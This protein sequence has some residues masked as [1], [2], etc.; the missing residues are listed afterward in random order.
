MTENVWDYP[1]PPRLE[2]VGRRVRIVLGGVTIVDTDDALRVL[3]TSHPPTVYV[4]PGAFADGVLQDADGSSYCEWKG[5]ARYHD[6]AAGG[7]TAAR[8][9]WSYP[10]PTKGFLDLRD[11][12]S[13][14]PSRMEACYLDEERVQAQEGDFYGGWITDDLVGPF[15]GGPGTRGW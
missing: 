10:R 2:P 11:H 14:Y 9:G 7:T 3:E 4:P 8:A 1:R 5:V 6:L 15:K 13:V 12:V